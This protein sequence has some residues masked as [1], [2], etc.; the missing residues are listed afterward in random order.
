VLRPWR[1]PVG[2][3]LG[4]TKDSRQ[5]ITDVDALYYGLAEIRESVLELLRP[6]LAAKPDGFADQLQH[7]AEPK[8]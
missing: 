4:A 7:R 3:F 6:A 8:G 5:A 1:E 2:C